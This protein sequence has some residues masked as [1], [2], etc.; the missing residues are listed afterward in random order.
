MRPHSANTPLPHC[1]TARFP[2]ARSG[3]GTSIILP[4][5]ANSIGNA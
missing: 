3:P 5:P 1:L 2:C 4:P